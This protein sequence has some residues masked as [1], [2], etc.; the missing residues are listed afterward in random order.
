VRPLQV[1]LAGGEDAFALRQ[2]VTASVSADP[3]YSKRAK[4]NWERS[5]LY[6]NTLAMY[7]G[8]PRK[9]ASLGEKDPLWANIQAAQEHGMQHAGRAS[10]GPI[11][12]A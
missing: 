2:R 10:L 4:Y 9:V 6:E 1:L 3:A 8:M 11:C 7:L 12:H 5:Q